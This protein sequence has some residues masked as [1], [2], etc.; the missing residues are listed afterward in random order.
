MRGSSLA[1]DVVPLEQV[2]TEPGTYS[3]NSRPD[4]HSRSRRTASETKRN[5]CWHYRHG[6]NHLDVR[7]II[8]PDAGHR[9]SRQQRVLRG[10]PEIGLPDR[11]H[12]VGLDSNHCRAHRAR[13]RFR[14]VR[15]TGM[16]AYRRRHRRL[17]QQDSELCVAAV[18]PV[19][20]VVGDRLRRVRYLGRDR[21]RPR[22]H[23][24]L[25]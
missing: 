17:R 2:N 8:R 9:R 4:V 25:A 15:W 14:A 21:A 23:R 7:R 12:D 11:H 5:G 1:D 18:L 22:H 20:G 3:T 6:G 16:G 24:R 10:D 13:R 19:V